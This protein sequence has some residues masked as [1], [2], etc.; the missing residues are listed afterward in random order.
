MLSQLEI[1][2][3]STT[4]KRRSRTYS[5]NISYMMQDEDT[6]LMNAVTLLDIAAGQAVR[7]VVAH[8]VFANLF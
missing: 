5:F 3:G 2:L 4:R 6:K 7:R 8:V 1:D